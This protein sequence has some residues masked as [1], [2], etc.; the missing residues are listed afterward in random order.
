[1]GLQTFLTRRDDEDMEPSL[2]GKEEQVKDMESPRKGRIGR[3]YEPSSYKG[4]VG[5]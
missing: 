3:R 5:R 2:F 4:G 1:M